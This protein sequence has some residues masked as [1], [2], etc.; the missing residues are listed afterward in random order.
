MFLTKTLFLDGSL[1][2]VYLVIY[3]MPKLNKN[4]NVMIFL[5]EKYYFVSGDSMLTQTQ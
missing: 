2:C 4:L 5:P 1:V 3:S